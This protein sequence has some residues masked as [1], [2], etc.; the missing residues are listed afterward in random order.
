M[1][2]EDV[3]VTWASKKHMEAKHGDG[4]FLQYAGLLAV[5]VSYT[6]HS[7]CRTDVLAHTSR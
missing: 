7:L 3:E 4:K 2:G 6:Y 1:T 5:S